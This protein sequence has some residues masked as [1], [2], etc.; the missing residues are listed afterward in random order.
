MGKK[1]PLPV[2]ALTSTASAVEGRAGWWRFESNELPQPKGHTQVLGAPDFYN[3][4]ALFK[5]LYTKF[6][7]S[8]THNYPA[9]TV[10]RKYKNKYQWPPER[11]ARASESPGTHTLLASAPARP[12]SDALR[13]LIV[14]WPELVSGPRPEA[15]EPLVP[16][17]C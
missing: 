12:G 17:E 15:G 1:L 3:L 10:H 14:H 5:E 16:C 2:V 13:W 8:I 11:G 9:P 7:M 6:Y 4:G